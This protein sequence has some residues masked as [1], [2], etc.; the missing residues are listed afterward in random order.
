MPTAFHVF[1][2]SLA[3][4]VF[5]FVAG[6]WFVKQISESLRACPPGAICPV[7]KPRKKRE[8]KKTGKAK[9]NVLLTPAKVLKQG[10]ASFRRKGFNRHELSPFL[11]TAL[12]RRRHAGKAG[13]A[14]AVTEAPEATARKRL[15]Q[16]P[17]PEAPEVTEP[18]DPE[19]PEMLSNG[20]SAKVPC[21]PGGSA[22][23]PPKSLK[24]LIAYLKK[25]NVPKE[26]HPDAMPSGAKGYTKRHSAKENPSSVQVLHQKE[27]YYLNYNRHGEVPLSRS[28]TWS[29]YGGA[30]RAWEHC[31]NTW[32]MF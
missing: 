20:G 16:L 10:A 22:K 26:L 2:S 8:P 29:L 5:V 32:E 12:K 24:D 13:K 4:S 11:I 23:V 17:G 31:K 6:P 1:L 19:A 27:M 9:K 28:I 14:T 15:K 21:V 18:K 7:I 30:D 3:L 25:W